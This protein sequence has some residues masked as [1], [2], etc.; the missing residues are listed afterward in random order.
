M[1]AIV[2]VVLVVLVVAAIVWA[3]IGAARSENR[4][5]ETYEHALGVLGEV[6]KR[7]ESTGFRILPHDETGRPHVGRP[8]DEGGGEPTGEPLRPRPPGQGPLTSPRLPPAGPPKLRFSRPGGTGELAPGGERTDGPERENRGA[9]PMAG[10]AVGAAGQRPPAARRRVPGG[11]EGGRPGAHQTG[12]QRRRQVMA[13]RAA[14]GGAAAVAVAAVVLAAVSL[15]GGGGGKPGEVT[16]TTTVHHSG[17]GSTTTSS[18]TTSSTT[19]TIPTTLKPTSVTASVVSFT[20]PTGPYTLDFQATGGACWIGIKQNVD[21]PWLFAETLNNGGS[22]T[23]H[24]SGA[25]VVTLGAPDYIGLR[26][27]GLLAQLP[28]GV[29]QSYSVEL[30]PTSG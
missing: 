12:L 2:V 18:S 1:I 14:T 24:A 13:R 4:S 16:T 19:T 10:A 8:I 17:G 11:S 7:T 22:T 30:T 21:G 15:T 9:G 5:V 6:S 29:T 20:A 23:Y 26:V 3:R 28:T 25:L 27:N